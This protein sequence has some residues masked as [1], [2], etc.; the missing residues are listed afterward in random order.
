MNKLGFKF[1]WETEDTTENTTTNIQ[2]NIAEHTLVNY[3]LELNQKIQDCE[4]YIISNEF[5]QLNTREKLQILDTYQFYI[6]TFTMFNG[7]D[8]MVDIPD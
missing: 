3:I 8:I 5:S 4:E 6:K 7:E 1:S 2:A